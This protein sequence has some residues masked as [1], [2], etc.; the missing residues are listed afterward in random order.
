MSSVGGLIVSPWLLVMSI[1]SLICGCGFI[2]VRESE[3]EGGA[4]QGGDGQNVGWRRRP[5]GR[6]RV[7]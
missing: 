7:A 6:K 4:I 5:L 3:G 2:T 1:T